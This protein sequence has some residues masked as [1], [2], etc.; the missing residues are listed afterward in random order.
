MLINDLKKLK[1]I[2]ACSICG[3]NN[4]NN[5]GKITNKRNKLQSAFAFLYDESYQ[6]PKQL[7]GIFD[8]IQCSKCNHCCLSLMPSQ[9]FL[10]SLYKNSSS[11][12]NHDSKVELKKK[13]NY[14]KKKPDVIVPNFNHWI[15]KYLK[16]FKP[17]NYFEVGPGTCKLLNMFKSKNWNCEGYEVKDWIVNEYIYNDFDS[18]PKDK[19]DVMVISDVLEHVSNPKEF[20]MSFTFLLKK[21]GLLFLA[22]PNASSYRAKILKNKWRMISPLNH[23]NFFS[24]K[25]STRMLEDSGFKIISHKAFSEVNIKKLLKNIIKLP[26][27]IILDLMKLNI[28]KA[29]RRLF[30]TI[31]NIIDLI[32]GDQTHIIAIKND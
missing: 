30:E 1:K 4:F 15:F 27:L 9:F 29:V 19:K 32:Y 22:F 3:N 20:L 10:D 5:L 17:G 28:Q 31:I 14:L 12:L 16:D 6:V 21:S 24:R 2:D 8:L 18:I 7:D 26:F 13:N 25:S 23:V 11:Y